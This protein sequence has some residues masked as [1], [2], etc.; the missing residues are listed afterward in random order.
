MSA[1]E[2]VGSVVALLGAGLLA[3]SAVGLH[4]FADPA[5]RLHVAAKASSAGVLVVLLG[6]G[7]RASSLSVALEFG[8]TGLFLVLTVPIA[9]HALAGARLAGDDDHDVGPD[10]VTGEPG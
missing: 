7:L 9:T 10:H 6:M 3:A 8:L 4:R 2:L 5:V 1:L